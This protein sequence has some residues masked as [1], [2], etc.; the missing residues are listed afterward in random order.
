MTFSGA[1]F[2]QKRRPGYYADL[3]AR[4]VRERSVANEKIERDLYRSPP[5][6]PAFQ[7]HSKMGI[8]ALRRVL[9]PNWGSST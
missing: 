5:E 8:T 1:V 4:A 2:D 6:Y 7:T 3:A 9:F